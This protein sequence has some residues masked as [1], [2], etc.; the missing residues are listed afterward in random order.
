M[1]EPPSHDEIRRRWAETYGDQALAEPQRGRGRIYL[2][3]I[4]VV[5]VLGGGWLFLRNALG[6]T[7]APASAQAQQAGSFDPAK[8]YA[9]TPAARWG[10]GAD[11]IVL[12]A[13]VPVG[14]YSAQQVGAAEAAAKQVLIAG[15]LDNQ[16]LVDHDPSAFLAL[17]A[18]TMQT[19]VRRDIT[20]SGSPDY[21]DALTLLMPGYHLLP[22]P[23]KVNGSMTPQLAADGNL[24]IHL[25]YVFAYP[26]APSDPST[27]QYAWQD[28]A[29]ARTQ[30]DVETV[31]GPR[32]GAADHGLWLRN[33]TGYLADQS[34]AASDQGFLAP[35][36]SDQPAPGQPTDPEDPNAYFD[37]DHTLKLNVTC[38]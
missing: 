7:P 22:V 36:Y 13:P 26:F 30:V 12:P 2:A 6:G 3:V 11:G 34:C 28:V 15:H 9:N 17:L 24:V 19:D 16:E 33:A 38:K 4:I 25:N 21:G 32:Y 35:A 31:A 10:D 18:P 20:D 5:I 23:I 27:I 1:S 8:P 29:V 37:P 14:G